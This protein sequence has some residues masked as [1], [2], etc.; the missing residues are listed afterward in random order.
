[1]KFGVCCGIENLPLLKKYGYDYIELNFSKIT[2]CS[3]E[4]FDAIRRELEA[5]GLAAESFNG[6][7]PSSVSLNREA[8]YNYIREYCA[9][10]FARA[11]EI[12]GKTVVLGS[13]GSRK[14][15][16]G[17]DR[18][19]AEEQFVQV[20]RICGE[21]AEKRGITVAIEP[22]R[23]KECNFINTVEE[24]MEFVRRAN[25]PNVK[26]LADF[27][28][29]AESGESLHAIETAG[30]N[31]AHVHLALPESRLFPTPKDRPICEVWKAALQKCGYD[32]RISLE[33]KAAPDVETAVREAKAALEIFQ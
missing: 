8:D 2:T 33:G 10:G 31:L 9:T 28:H 32:A 29:V 20:L 7:F 15:P 16:E 4:E 21:E 19:T 26:C 1:M 23:V 18:S 6:F 3:R 12:G 24:G 17:Y 13:G 5:W 22:L 30:E 14:I 11:K 27:F 25:H